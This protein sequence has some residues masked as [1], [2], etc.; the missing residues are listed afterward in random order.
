[1]KKNYDFVLTGYYG[2]GNLGDELLAE[3]AYNS[4]LRCG[5]EKNRIA[6]LTNAP[7]EYER[8]FGCASYHRT[9]GAVKTLRQSKML[10][11]GGG[12]IFQDSSSVASCVY[13]FV[14]ALLAHLLSGRVAFIG[15]SV[16]PFRSS[17][18]RTFAHAAFALASHV[19]VRDE[20]SARIIRSF[21][22]KCD[23]V[24]D[25]VL[26][27]GR[28]NSAHGRP[29]LLFNVRGGYPDARAA[30][31]SACTDL[32]RTL[33]LPVIGIA[34]SDED[35]RELEKI[36]KENII[37]L[38]KIIVV[39]SYDDFC[40]AAAG[41]CGAVGMRLHFL[42]MASLLGIP[43]AASPYDPKITG[44]CENSGIALCGTPPRTANKLFISSARARCDADM[45]NLL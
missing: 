16:G 36:Q 3:A 26:S 15:Q 11:F 43:V 37:E 23:I 19:S 10:V 8:K 35:R 13:Y 42:V 41:A 30:A 7:E 5:V 44:F 25:I 29:V 38:K 12:G 20:Q 32:V 31:C 6:F 1:M 28:K 21:G 39:K 22:I 40:D 45:R 2:F 33:N 4:L 27:L 24:P 34:L 18:S 9:H 17:V 14:L